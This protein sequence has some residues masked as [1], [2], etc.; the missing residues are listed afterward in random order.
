MV[1]LNFIIKDLLTVYI[2]FSYLFIGGNHKSSFNSLTI[3]KEIDFIADN[4]ENVFEALESEIS[5][6]D[7]NRLQKLN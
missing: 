4:D 1:F 3:L 2:N 5:S 6:I 7:K